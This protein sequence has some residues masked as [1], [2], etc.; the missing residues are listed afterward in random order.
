MD[1]PLMIDGF[2]FAGVAAG[3]KRTGALDLAL[4]VADHPVA[5]AAVFTRSLLR[6][7][8]VE[9][10]AERIGLGRARAVLFNS[11]NANA[12]TGVEGM[13]LAERS[14]QLVAEALGARCDEILVG[15]TG[16]IGVQLAFDAFET[17]IPNLV[18]ALR[19]E[20][21]D[22]FSRAILT[23]DRGPKVA[24]AE[25]VLPNGRPGRVL[26]IGK[27]AGMIHPDMATTLVV[28]CTDV[29]ATPAAIDSAL[30]RATDLTFNRMT[31]DG[32][33]STNDTIVAMASGALGN[34]PIEGGDALTQLT[35]AFATVLGAVGRMIVA[36]GEGAERVVEVRITSAPSTADA[37]QVARTIAT[38]LLVKTAIHGC[39]PN[40]G[41]ILAAAARAGVTFDPA[42]A[43]VTVAG[44]AVY[45]DGAPLGLAADE[46][47]SEGMK[48]ESYAIDVDLAAGE[49]EGQYLTCD[50]GHEYVRINAEYRT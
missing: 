7:A 35:E 8:P 36:D 6:A 26:A 34:T 11:G 1:D 13:R 2:R 19:P 31:V 48:A 41:R 10:S 9:L 23:T 46:K 15:S 27:G 29:A 5:A 21:A 42:A 14:T 25:V 45:R 32:D 40:W 22:D 17:G 30:R 47:A 18:A 39:D 3:I 16:V 20:G 44:V 28:V 50:L 33:T 49:H 4:V 24:S 43:A 37:Q 38:S 12:A